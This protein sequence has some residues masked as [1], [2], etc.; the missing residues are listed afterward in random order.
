MLSLPDLSLHS[1][2]SSYNLFSSFWHFQQS[3]VLPLPCINFPLPLPSQLFLAFL[4]LLL[5]S[6]LLTPSNS[7]LA[8]KKKGGKRHTKLNLPFLPTP[9]PSFQYLPLPSN[10]L[11]LIFPC[12]RLP[13]TPLPLVPTLLP[14]CT[15]LSFFQH[16]FSLHFLSASSYTCHPIN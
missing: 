11:L 5:F 3:S 14:P 15:V 7:H 10:T 12:F 4:L 6:V 13:L 2:L 8:S 1:T 9:F 16:P